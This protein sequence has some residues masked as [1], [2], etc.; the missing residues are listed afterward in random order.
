M[1]AFARYGITEFA[2][3]FSNAGGF[4]TIMA[5]NYELK[6]FKKE[7]QKMRELTDKPFGV[8]ITVDRPRGGLFN[9]EAN[10]EDYLNYLEVA[11]N[12]GVNVFTT[13]AY[14]ALF[15]A[16]RIHE[17]GC[18]WF[19]KCPLMRHA[20]SAEEA[21]ADAITLMGMESA[22]FKNPYQHSTMVNLTM[23][24]RILKVPLIAA[25]G[26]GDA[27]GLLGALAMG[28]DAVCLGT[29][30]LTTKESPLSIER[31][32][33]RLDTDIFTEDYHRRLYHRTLSGTSVPS[34]SIGFQKKI[35]PLKDL[36][37]SLMNNAEIILKSFGFTKEKFTTITS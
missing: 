12:A 14:Q 35:V 13:S 2:A 22:G 18:Y 1:A 15:I 9:A 7:L 19:P 29:A 37:E 3:S 24:K 25:G 17:A 20:I 27:R 34:P 10:K 23:G 31:K 11:I 16:E 8:N 4:G 28:A 26:I 5:L 30:I 6:H 32:L 33:M 21:G 36:I